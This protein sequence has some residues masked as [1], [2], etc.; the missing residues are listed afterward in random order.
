V[1]LSPASDGPIAV[2]RTAAVDY[3]QG[4]Y[5]VL[6]QIVRTEL[7]VEE[8]LLE[9]A[10]TDGAGSAGSTSA[11]RQTT[12]TGGAVL[13]ACREIRDELERRGLDPRAIEGP[14]SRTYTYH[15]R[16]TSGFDEN[17]HG[18][19]HVAFSFAAERAVV[20]VDEELGLVRVVQIAAV[21]DA[22]RVVN[23]QGAMGQVEGGTAMGIGLALMEELQVEGGVIRNASFTDYLI[24]TILDAPPVVTE[25]VEEPE[26]GAP[27]GVKGVGELGAVVGAPAVVAALR[28]AVGR[29]LNRVPVTPDD[30]LGLRP[31]ATTEGRPPVPDVPGQQAIPEYHGLGLGQQQLMQRRE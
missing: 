29:P 6:A 9:P 25:F 26:P 30:L 15:H 23:P 13:A 28:D 10:T 4:L 24:P 21:Q 12:M 20:E 1:T 18:D 31:P 11:S 22:G 27:Y 14:I 16:P 8:V 5:T 2:V 19:I 7:G 17:G 3:G